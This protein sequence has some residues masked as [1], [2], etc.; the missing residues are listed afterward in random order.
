MD[1][2]N[3]APIQTGDNLGPLPEISVNIPPGSSPKA[4]Y[5][6]PTGPMRLRVN[7]YIATKGGGERD[8]VTERNIKS[9]LENW[10]GRCYTLDRYGQ[11]GWSYWGIASAETRGS[12]KVRL[13]RI[14]LSKTHD[15]IVSAYLDKRA[16]KAWTGGS[17]SWRQWLEKE[18]VG[19]GGADDI[20]TRDKLPPWIIDV[21]AADSDTPAEGPR[22]RY[23]DAPPEQTSASQALSGNVA[24]VD[25]LLMSYPTRTHKV[26]VNPL[27][28]RQPS[29]VESPIPRKRA[30][31]RNGAALNAKR[32]APTRR[33][34]K[35][36]KH[37]FLSR[38][39]RRAR[40]RR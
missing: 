36:M 15:F 38:N 40:T 19:G 13:Q 28:L 11:E 4:G 1:T 10:V 2:G 14:V 16:G 25:N 32:Q 37:P 24:P 30:R 39:E 35:R 3:N 29:S 34:V 33:S 9:I 22:Y 20:E 6:G 7:R 12:D 18:C 8:Y 26:M 5:P 17:S 31:K 27:A 21:R 23:L